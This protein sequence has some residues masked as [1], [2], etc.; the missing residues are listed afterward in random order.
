MKQ[1]YILTIFLTNII[2]LAAQE[3]HSRF[4]SIDIQ[5]YIFEIHLNDSTDKIEGKTTVFAKFLKPTQKATLDLVGFEGSTKTGMQ[6]SNILVD[7]ISTK[8]T[9]E[10]NQVLL[11]FNKTYKPD[12]CASVI[13]EYSG[14]PADGLVISKNKFGD[15]TFF[16]DNWPD[17]AKHWLPTIDHPS[18]KA[19]LEF[20]VFAPEHYKVVSN[21]YLLKETT[22]KKGVKLTHWKETIPI[23]TKLMVIGVARFEVKFIGIFNSIPVSTW[24]FP[25]NRDDGFLD[26]STGGKPL[27]FF[28]EIIGQYSYEKLAHVQSKTRYGGMENA[29][30]IFYSEKSVTGKNNL[31]RLIAHETAHQW[32]GNSVTEQNWHH[33]WLSEGFATYF[34]HVYKQNFYGEKI[35]REGL[36]ND[37]KKVIEFAYRNLLPVIDTTVTNYMRL[38]NANSYQ[39]AS[40]FLQMLRERTG[41]SM[42]FESVQEYYSVFKDSTALTNDFRNIAEKVSKQDLEAFFQQWLWQPGFPKINFEW[43][44]KSNKKLKLKITQTQAEFLFTFPLDIELQ[45]K[46]GKREIKKVI[47][48]DWET[49][50]L[51]QVEGKVENIILDPSVKLLFEIVQ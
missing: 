14:I 12:E 11:H 40:W 48:D 18:D 46:N 20:R 21:G 2:T 24:V 5:Q 33:I 17:R 25:Q 1:I 36:V 28:S 13:I 38:L 47:I 9:H 27:K 45:L 39:K 22:L 3:H 10:N 4:E 32:F 50:V 15:R 41:D 43:K 6:I 16:G 34:T 35:F 8:Y 37:R 31:E 30:C 49:E 29:G 23:P 51:F 42:F 7:S 44:Q 19:S 26:Y